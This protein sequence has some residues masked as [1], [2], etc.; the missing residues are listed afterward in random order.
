MDLNQYQR[1]PEIS[2]SEEYRRQERFS[3]SGKNMIGGPE[4][5]TKKMTKQ[6]GQRP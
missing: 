4:F 1:T 3:I 2:E 5:R 6:I